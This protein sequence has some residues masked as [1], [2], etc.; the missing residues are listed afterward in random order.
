MPD[1]M[2]DDMPDLVRVSVWLNQF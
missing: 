2:P 1:D